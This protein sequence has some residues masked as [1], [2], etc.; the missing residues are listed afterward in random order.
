MPFQL[1]PGVVTTEI[2]LTTIVPQ[3]GVSGGGFAGVTK[4]GPALE[5]VQAIDTQ[6]TFRDTFKDWFVAAN[7]LDYGSNLTFVRAI[8]TTARNA[9]AAGITTLV[10]KNLDDYTIN[11]SSGDSAAGNWAGKY[12]G[13]FANQITVSIADAGNYGNW[14]YKQFFSGAPNTST[15]VAAKGGTN[16]ELH[17]V[18]VDTDGHITGTA[19][20]VL[21]RYAFLSKAA[22]AKKE[23]GTSNYYPE[24]VNRLSNYI[25]WTDHPT[26]GTNWGS[27]SQNTA[28]TTLSTTLVFTTVNSGPFVTDEI[29]KVQS[30]SV[31]GTTGLG[32]GSGYHTGTTTIV[33]EAPNQP[34]GVTATGT[35]TIASSPGAITAIV[36]TNEGSG[37]TNTPTYTIVDTNGSPGSGASVTP[38]VTYT[39][40]VKTGIVT[41]YNSGT[42]TVTYN[43]TL[44]KITTDDIVT[45]VTSGANGIPTTVTGQD[46]IDV[47]TAGVDGNDTIDDSDYITANDLFLDA[48]HVPISLLMAGQA[49]TT[50]ALHL[51]QS[52]AEVRKDIVVFISPPED[53]VVNNPGNEVADTITFRNTLVSSS[54]AFMDSN[55]KYQLDVYNDT[56]RWVPCNGDIAGLAVATD[57]S[58]DPWY[59]FAGLNRGILK[60][61]V[62]LAWQPDK[63]DRDSLYPNGINPITKFNGIGPVL[64]GDKTMLAKPS[65]FDRVNVRRLFIV[66]EKSIATAAKYSLFEFNDAFTQAQFRILI[67]PFLRD[68]MG[69]RGIT[70]F[71]VVCD[72][73]N[74]TPQ[75]VDSNEFV[76]DI[77]IKPARSINFITLNFIATPTGVAF[78]EIVGKTGAGA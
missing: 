66:L 43:A 64:F 69:R 22:D 3:I 62:K 8:S 39:K 41:G 65:A 5:A 46:V 60:N 73:T 28:F 14:A 58:R 37:Y 31:T 61:V 4:W 52:I 19:G 74:N 57:Q 12:P 76:G 9:N 15:Y 16:D 72:S 2:D 51:I 10:I 20:E 78:S 33:F 35:V 11:F 44:G 17:I 47:L 67:E 24:V 1:S 38:V 49:S 77:Y 50:V 56:F 13:D 53:A 70:D 55:W 30:G 54:Y 48:E 26:A 25:W 42:K 63:A 75:V 68:V 36:I 71:L 23:D 27:L 45:G 6:I 32:G 40:I 34:G 59:S 18:L 29:I 21:E 7:F